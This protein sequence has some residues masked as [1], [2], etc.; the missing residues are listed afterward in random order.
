MLRSSSSSSSSLALDSTL[1]AVALH[2]GPTGRSI[3]APRLRFEHRE[4][5][6]K[7]AKLDGQRLGKPLD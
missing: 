6:S 1:L 5:A 3:E 7:A 2:A 4:S